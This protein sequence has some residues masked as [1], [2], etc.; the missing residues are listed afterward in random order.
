[1]PEI[2]INSRRHIRDH[3]TFQVLL[4]FE[5]ILDGKNASPGMAQHI[6]LFQS[7]PFSALPL[8]RLYTFQR[9]IASDRSVFGVGG[10]KLIVVIKLDSVLRQEILEALEVSMI[11]SRTS[12]KQQ[13]LRASAPYLFR[14]NPVPPPISIR[15]DP[16]T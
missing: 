4:I 8:L 3:N 12:V 10:V 16:P 2:R 15:R 6:K 13:Y 9:S 5:R 1:M 11:C 7:Q 14:P